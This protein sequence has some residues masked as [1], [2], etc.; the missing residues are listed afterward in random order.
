MSGPG[1]AEGW[2]VL[3][4]ESVA[5]VRKIHLRRVRMRMPDGQEADFEVIDTPDVAL[6]IPFLADRSLV[7]VRQFRPPWNRSSWECPAGTLEPGEGP[8]AGG[9]RE[10]AEETGYRGGVWRRVGQFH[11]TALYTGRFHLF[12]VDAPEPGPSRPDATEFLEVRAFSV[13]DVRQLV[14][15]GEMVHG[16]SLAALGMCGILRP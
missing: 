6:M 16:P 8:E 13:P 11:A 2:S 1:G 10:L 12:R 7:L 15:M 14:A 9:R 5:R 4:Q 3:G